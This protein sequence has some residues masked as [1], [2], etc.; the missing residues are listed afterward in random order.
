M[1]VSLLPMV[2]IVDE[3]AGDIHRGLRRAQQRAVV[4][5]RHL[6]QLRRGLHVPG[7]DQRRERVT[8]QLVEY[9]G[10]LR[11]RHPVEIAHLAPSQN[12][13]ALVVKIVVKAHQLQGRPVHVRNGHNGVVKIPALV[14]DLHTEDLHHLFQAGRCALDFLHTHILP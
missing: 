9:A 3:L 4:L 10:A 14:E 7:N 11:L 2:Q 13:Q 12:L 1:A 5:L 6:H 8:Q